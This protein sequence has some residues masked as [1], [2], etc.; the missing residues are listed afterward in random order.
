M[1]AGVCSRTPPCAAHAA[2]RRTR[3]PRRVDVQS[4]IS[5]SRTVEA[6]PAPEV[7]VPI[8]SLARLDLSRSA[9][10]SSPTAHGRQRGHPLPLGGS[11]SIATIAR[12]PIIS[13]TRMTAGDGR[14]KVTSR[15]PASWGS[16]ERLQDR[17]VDERD[18][19]HVNG[20]R[21]ASVARSVECL[22]DQGHDVEIDVAVELDDQLAVAFGR[23]YVPV[24]VDWHLFLSRARRPVSAVHGVARDVTS[25]DVSS[26][27]RRPASS[28]SFG[29]R[30][31][32]ATVR[33]PTE[34]RRVPVP[35]RH[36]PGHGGDAHRRLATGA[37]TWGRWRGLTPY[38]PG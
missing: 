12:R 2:R 37:G 18:G 14:R 32:A 20:E 13:K 19:G 31:V 7:P 8:G 30:V 1:K 34:R 11:V 16:Q 9:C 24:V 4:T 36:P 35:P 10:S 23:P 38:G 6:P 27:D 5:R 22:P 28:G 3:G 26:K 21:P 29:R 25:P 17:R 15:P 33:V